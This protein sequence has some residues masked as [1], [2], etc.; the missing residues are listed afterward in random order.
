M[1][2]A[3]KIRVGE[4]VVIRN[5]SNDEKLNKYKL[6]DKHIA[7]PI[8]GIDELPSEKVYDFTTVAETHTMIANGFIT[9]N[10]PVETPEHAKIGLTK[11]LSMIGSITIMSRDQYYLLS[12][13]LVKRLIR[14]SD[15]PPERL[16]EANIYKVLL[17]GDWI[18]LTDDAIKL[19]DDM[20]KKRLEGYF[21]IQNTSIVRDDDENEIRVYCDSGRL[22]RPVLRVE[23]NI[24]K[25]KKSHINEISLNKNYK[26]KIT[27]FNEF[28]IKHPDLID[29]IDTELQPYVMVSYKMKKIEEMRN[30]M[31]D[32][33]EK[34]KDIK[35]SHVE[36]RYDDMMYVKYN[37]CEFHPSL[38][39][40]E[41]IT[42]APFC[43]MNAGQRNI[44]QYA[45]GRQAMTI[46]ATNYRSR[47]DISYILY[48]PQRSLVYTR[49]SIY[50]NT[51]L[52]P[53]GENCLVAIGCY[54]G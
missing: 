39:I 21:N 43:N 11:H 31:I 17:N 32:S 51:R 27:T 16:R 28:M 48:K 36:N 53:P 1:K 44:F 23:N 24:V 8:I 20:N 50:T 46:Y 18:G 5:E 26:D 40:G 38:L 47:L 15:L 30:R 2:D 12:D 4:L 41:I 14:I 45:Q 34:I 29:Y 25:L 13:Y 37:Y 19:S 6:D 35:S 33:I 3:G 42:N 9:S 10:C 52:L 22:Y 7:V 49:S 54:T